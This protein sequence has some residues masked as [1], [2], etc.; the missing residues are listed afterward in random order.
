MP[1]CGH[2]A[3]WFITHGFSRVG[4]RALCLCVRVC[5]CVWVRQLPFRRLIAGARWRQWAVLLYFFPLSVFGLLH[6]S[7]LSFSAAPLIFLSTRAVRSFHPLFP[8]SIAPSLCH[9]SILV[10]SSKVHHSPPE[11]R[12]KKV[13]LDFEWELFPQRTLIFSLM[14]QPIQYW[15]PLALKSESKSS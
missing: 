5:V 12:G 2:T 3:P 9:S 13:Y 10:F 1:C 15:V 14:L 7:F 8:F 4:R 11:Q 6:R